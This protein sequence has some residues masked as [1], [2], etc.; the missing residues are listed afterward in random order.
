MLCKS[1]EYTHSITVLLGELYLLCCLFCASFIQLYASNQ[2]QRNPN[3]TLTMPQ[4]LYKQYPDPLTTPSTDISLGHLPPSTHWSKSLHGCALCALINQLFQHYTH[5][6]YQR[7]L[8]QHSSHLQDQG[9]PVGSS[10]TS[11]E[12]Y[13]YRLSE[14]HKTGYGC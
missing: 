6:L 3:L 13:L 12:G 10:N 2:M 14:N 5:T 1:S 11:L 4:Y 9:E 7:Y 8:L